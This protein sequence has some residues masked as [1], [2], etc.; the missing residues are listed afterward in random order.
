MPS[1]TS[2]RIKD[3]FA[4]CLFSRVARLGSFSAAARECGLSQSQASRII[5]DLEADL[6][7]QLLSRTTR[8]VVPTEPGSEFLARIEPILGALDEAEHSVR[9]GGELHGLVRVSMPTSA[10]VREI[11]PRLS[12]FAAQHPQLH[13]RFLLE[14]RRQDLVRDAVDLAIR[15][16]RQADSSATVK[17]IATVP[18]VILAAPSYLERFGM[19]AKPED[20]AEHRI[21]G[22]PASDVPNAW[23]F[24][25]D[26]EKM[27]LDLQP[28]ISTNENE[29]AVAAVTAGMGI[30][31]TT[32]WACR[33]ELE[34][35][36][37]VRLFPDW[38]TID[39]PVY[40]LFPMGRAT[41]A[42]G[43]AIVDFLVG[44]FQSDSVAA[45]S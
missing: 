32:A 25:R 3:V 44:E 27:T 19:P 43:R 7:A 5:A 33:R 21:V 30:T 10:G 15:M 26:G 18:R 24:E 2:G 39:I 37:L 40:A 12:G 9:E 11:I 4:L 31:S 14:D 35:G 42:A 45:K 36:S 20:L 13:I 8:A 23:I 28:H 38:T 34:D 16:G 17:L 1:S 29:G 22:G 6:G 41:R